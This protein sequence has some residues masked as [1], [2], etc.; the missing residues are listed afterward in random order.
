MGDVYVLMGGCSGDRHV[1]GI[2]DDEDKALK[3]QHII[4]EK[5]PFVAPCL[6]VW[7]MNEFGYA[8]EQYSDLMNESKDMER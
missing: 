1:V 7:E 3:A 6:E 8:Y 2:F 5:E 4:E